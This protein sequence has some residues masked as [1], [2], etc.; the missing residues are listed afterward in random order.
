M[1]ETEGIQ[2]L[3]DSNWTICSPLSQFFLKIFQLF[4]FLPPHLRLVEGRRRLRRRRQ[5]NQRG[6]RWGNNEKKGFTPDSQ[7]TWLVV[8]S[9]KRLRFGRPDS[10][11]NH[12]KEEYEEKRHSKIMPQRLAGN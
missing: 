9:E 12:N 4:H 8:N 3:G 5:R 11:S 7:L 1:D 2:C 6:T 10:E